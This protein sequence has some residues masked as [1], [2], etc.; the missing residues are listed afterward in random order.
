MQVKQVFDF[1][2]FFTNSEQLEFI[3]LLLSALMLWIHQNHQVLAQKDKVSEVFLAQ[4]FLREMMQELA[5]H[6]HL[7][8]YRLHQPKVIIDNMFNFLVL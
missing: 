8:H 5:P 2:A 1:Q 4:H 6:H 7:P 3:K